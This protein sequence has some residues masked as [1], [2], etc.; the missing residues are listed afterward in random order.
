MPGHKPKASTR[1]LEK[2]KDSMEYHLGIV[3][4]RKLKSVKSRVNRR[5]QMK[6]RENHVHKIK[7]EL[8]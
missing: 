7:M 6:L 1:K 2:G 3:I 8:P 4:F 5:S